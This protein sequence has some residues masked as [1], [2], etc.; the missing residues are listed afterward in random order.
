MSNFPHS[1]LVSTFLCPRETEE[2]GS[3][4]TEEFRS[5]KTE[6]FRS[7]KTEYFVHSE[8]NPSAVFLA[9]SLSD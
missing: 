3:R 5:R 2:F 7:R 8:R 6:E 1:M 4:K 9:C